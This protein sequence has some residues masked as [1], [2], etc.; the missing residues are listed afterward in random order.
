MKH[1][2]ALFLAGSLI[3]W[4][5][6]HNQAHP[7]SA[8]NETDSLAAKDSASTLFFPVGDYLETE[9]L[10]VDS[11]PL[12]V[13]R[14]TIQKE[15]T[16][17]AYIQP[18]EFNTLAR[19]FLL[20]EFKDG[21][22][23]KNYTETSFVDKSTHSATFTYSTTDKTLPLQRVDV[24]TVPGVRANKVKS[25]Y[26]QKIIRTGDTAVVKKLY[27]RAGRNFQILTRTNV[28]GMPSVEKQVRVVWN[29]DEEDE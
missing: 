10:Y 24:I 13:K 29:N 26:I 7:A 15:R 23:Q 28:P 4:T 17:S 12:A 18:A 21:S 14:Y 22:F 11:T 19:E 9:I 1:L 2:V 20:P 3:C 25:I 16:D 8:A 27:W 5:A 6:C